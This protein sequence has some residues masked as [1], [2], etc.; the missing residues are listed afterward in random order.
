MAI[1]LKGHKE[2]M[3]RIFNEEGDSIPVTVIVVKPNKVTQ[4]KSTDTDGYN[5]IQVT[6]GERNPN[7]IN[8]AEAGHFAK[9]AIQP[10][11][12][13]LEFRLE[14]NQTSEQ[15]HVGQEF[16]VDMFNVGD[17]VDVTGITLGKGFAGCIKR[18]N[19]SS[20]RQSHG[21]SVSHRAPGSIGQ[22]QTPGRVFKGKK[23]A[24]RMGNDQ[25]TIQNLKV[26]RVDLA[27]GL[28]LVKG[29]VPGYKG[30]ELIVRPAV[31]Y[32]QS[33]SAVN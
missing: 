32:A 18:H 29:S 22:N 3:T 11:N 19:F 31:K 23:M 17:M 1:G 28:I 5:A 15:F 14:N 10:G 30:R 20:Q 8:K 21:N 33:R 4:V 27:R 2:G 12:G 26:I 16:N 9:A 6:S 13:L 25:V 24:G 7:K